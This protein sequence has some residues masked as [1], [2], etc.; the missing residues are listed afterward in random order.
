MRIIA[1]LRCHPN[2]HQSDERLT[3]KTVDWLQKNLL[4][5]AAGVLIQTKYILFYQEEKG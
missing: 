5:S 1:L 3:P 4:K 2:D